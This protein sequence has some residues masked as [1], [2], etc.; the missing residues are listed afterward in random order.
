MT[1]SS[2]EPVQSWRALLVPV[3]G[4]IRD[5][6]VADRDDSGLAD[7][8]RLIGCD[9]VEHVR[10]PGCSLW[11]DEEGA[12][13]D[14]PRPPNPRIDQLLRRTDGWSIRGDVVITGRVREDG[15]IR[16]LTADEAAQLRSRLDGTE[17]APTAGGSA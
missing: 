17:Y 1:T 3:A 12:V 10:G 6:V 5:V 8:Y 16:A 14:P 11:V 13:S 7:L 4:P 15:D 9:Y 2:Q